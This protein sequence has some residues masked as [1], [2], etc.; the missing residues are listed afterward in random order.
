M[1]SQTSVPQPQQQIELSVEEK[2]KVIILKNKICSK[3]TVYLEKTPTN[4]LELLINY[5]NLLY[6]KYKMTSITAQLT[7]AS[8]RNGNIEPRS[9][10]KNVEPE[11]IQFLVL[12]YDYVDKKII[13]DRT[14]QT[15]NDYRNGVSA[16]S[17][18]KPENEFLSTMLKNSTNIIMDLKNI[19]LL[20]DLYAFLE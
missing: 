1:D 17:L 11:E 4:Q 15:S 19:E 18:W 5:I 14:K 20:N 10:I 9:I 6:K 7:D 8:S 2:L 12:F 13:N 16:S 3:L